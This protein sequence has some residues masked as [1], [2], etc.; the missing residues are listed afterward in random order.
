MTFQA[1]SGLEERVFFEEWQELAFNKKT[2]NV[3][4]YND[5]VS[6]VDIYILN[7]QDQR[8]FGIKLHG[9]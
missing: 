7:R 6:E 9:R 2:W 8:Q 1:I 4:Y 5:Y 3:G